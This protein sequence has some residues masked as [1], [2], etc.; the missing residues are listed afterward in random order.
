MKN[1]EIFAA[2][3][4]YS[5]REIR[6]LIR[7]N[8]LLLKLMTKEISTK[9]GGAMIGSIIVIIIVIIAA[10]LLFKSNAKKQ[11]EAVPSTEQPVTEQPVTEQNAPATPPATVEDVDQELNNLD[12]DL[13]GLDTTL[14]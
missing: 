14:E 4:E 1:H 13:Q 5:R 9:K 2:C 6:V 7:A 8:S 11:Q 10:I 3:P 12:T